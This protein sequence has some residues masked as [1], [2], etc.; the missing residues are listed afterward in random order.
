MRQPSYGPYP[1]EQGDIAAEVR[2]LQ[3]LAVEVSPGPIRVSPENG[4]DRARSVSSTMYWTVLPTFG[5]SS[6]PRARRRMS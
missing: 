4:R 3:K 2:R 5:R 6:S 1:P